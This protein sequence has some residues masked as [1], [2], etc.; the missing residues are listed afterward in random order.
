[1]I[2]QAN[3]GD[4]ST[5]IELGMMMHAESPRYRRHTFRADK[6]AT[7][8]EQLIDTGIVLL[9]E[10]DGEAIGMA[11]GFVMEQFFTDARLAADLAV[12]VVPAARGGRAFLRLVKAFE[13]RAV[14]LGADEISLGVSTD[15]DTEG[16]AGLYQRLGY[17]R[18]SIGMVKYVHT[19]S[20][21]RAAAG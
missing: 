20:G 5:L 19:E 13:A 17:R 18:A 1:M 8:G 3:R 10:E 12:Y 14:E 2:R 6:L 11:I 7:L 4:L 16:T 21:H 9:E 15:I